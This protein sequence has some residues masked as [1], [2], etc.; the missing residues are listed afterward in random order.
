MSRHKP[1][2][3]RNKQHA[4]RQRVRYVKRPVVLVPQMN[5]GKVGRQSDDSG[6][7]VGQR[8]SSVDK[9]VQEEPNEAHQA[10]RDKDKVFEYLGVCR[11]VD[12]DWEI[13]VVS[14]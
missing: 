3:S 14:L 7:Y 10:G 11:D 1:L 2:P 4:Q 6:D 8:D 12:L 5:K 9:A 13:F